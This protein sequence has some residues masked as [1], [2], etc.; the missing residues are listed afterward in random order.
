M[1]VFW[2]M[3]CVLAVAAVLLTW[4]PWSARESVPSRE[5]PAPSPQRSAPDDAAALR[6]A[7]SPGQAGDDIDA[8]IRELLA[9]PA[10]G[11][12][13][14]ASTDTIED[15]LADAVTP[16]DDALAP[17]DPANPVDG[18]YILGGSGTADDPYQITWDLLLLAA[19]TYVPREGRTDMPPRVQAMDGAHIKIEGYFAFPLASTDSREVLFML[20]MW[21]GCC[22]GVPPSPYDAIEVR[23]KEPMGSGGKQ[24]VNYGTLT[25]VLKVDPFVQ[26]GWLLGIYLMQEGSINLEL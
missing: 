25:G 23:L 10:D 12:S 16:S 17:F 26:D 18:A 1:R 7:T 11:D 8:L 4:Q 15:A 20:N 6:P 19:Q 14:A 3:V 24:F 5:A 2:I 9:P 21:D 13:R 22:I